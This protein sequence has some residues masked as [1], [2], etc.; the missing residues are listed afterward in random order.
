V[1]TTGAIGALYCALMAVLDPGDEVLIPDPGW[2]NYEARIA[3]TAA[4]DELRS[5]VTRL[6]QFLQARA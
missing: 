4:D 1:I 2:P 5:G 3:F 6:M